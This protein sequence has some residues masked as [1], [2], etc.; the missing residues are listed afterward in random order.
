MSIPIQI[1][2]AN[3]RPRRDYTQKFEEFTVHS[4]VQR[5]KH[6]FLL[7]SYCLSSPVKYFKRKRTETNAKGA[8][9]AAK[10]RPPTGSVLAPL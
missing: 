8:G 6:D 5:I 3:L 2:N 9:A 7:L 1:L 4:T 10:S